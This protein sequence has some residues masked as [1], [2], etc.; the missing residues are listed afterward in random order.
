MTSLTQVKQYGL[1]VNG[2][3]ETTAEKMEVLNKYT[4]QP[5]A[6]ISVATKND[7]NKAVASAKDALKNAF[8]PYERY[9]VLMKAAELL[10]S[11]QEEFAE[12]LATEVGKSIRES[13]GEVERA[14]TTLQ[15]SAEEAKRIHGE[16]VP[17]ESAQGSENRMAFTVKVPVGVVAA[18]TPFNVPI[19]LVCHKLGPALA[20]GNSVV[21]KPAEV[22]PICALKLA[23][24][25]E[26]AGLPKGRLQVLT[27]DGAE[28]GEWLLE[29]QDVNMFTFTGSPRVGEL[30]RSKAGLRKVSLELGNNS[31]TVVHKDADLEKAASLISQK[32][33]NNA[34]QVCISVQRIY[35]H[36][37]IY[38]AF[39]NKLKEKTEK[40][41]VGDPMDEQTDIGPMIRLKEAE[42]VEEWV[43]EAVEEGAKIEL[44]GKRD[45]AFYLPT[46]LTNVNDEMKVCRQEVFGPVVAIAKYDEIDEVISKVNDSDYGLQAG[47]FTN[48]LQFAMKAAREI[49]VGGL[50]VNDASA[51]RVDHMPYGGVKKSGNGKEGPKY[52]IEEMTEE[53]IIVLN[54]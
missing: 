26:E 40:L 17:V 29:N 43:K 25:M 35:V 16:G 37:N 41:V 38:T 11:R 10:L 8:S 30:I 15:I 50:I 39:V 19:N 44:G 1:Y 24:L 22:T 34:G 5:A 32:S 18:I 12:I 48:D 46:I 3:W 20:A 42:R 23:E 53:R 14:A 31:A 7:V 6:E 33:F 45:G 47:L 4:Q 49:E 13:R 52:A 54:L 9:E 28:I 2:E 27:G 21:L 51:Y 36:T